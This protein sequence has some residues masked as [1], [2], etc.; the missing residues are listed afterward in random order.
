M[1]ETNDWPAWVL[2]LGG[3]LTAIGAAV[4]STKRKPTEDNEMQVLKQRVSEL[5]RRANDTDTRLTE[6]FGLL[7]Q[8]DDGLGKCQSD[9]REALARLDERRKR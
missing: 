3:V 7:H 4:K 2:G 5:E 6:V 8:V 9:V 1:A